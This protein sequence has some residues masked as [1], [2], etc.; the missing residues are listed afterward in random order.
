MH[1]HSYRSLLRLKEPSMLLRCRK[2]D[3]HSVE[4]VLDSAKNEYAQKT[5]VHSPEVVVD[6]IYLP[7]A[8][9]HHDAHTRSCAGGTHFQ[10]WKN[11][12]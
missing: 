1:C 8:P 5:N 11:C 4:S 10:G 6:Q 3:L 9:S 12:V 2:D 7:P